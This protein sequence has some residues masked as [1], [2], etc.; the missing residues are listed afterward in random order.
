MKRQAEKNSKQVLESTMWVDTDL[1]SFGAQSLCERQVKSG[2]V[3]RQDVLRCLA[4]CEDSAEGAARLGPP[5]L[6][7]LGGAETVVNREREGGGD[8]RRGDGLPL[9]ALPGVGDVRGGWGGL[10]TPHHA[11]FSNKKQIAIIKVITI[12]NTVETQY[13]G[14]SL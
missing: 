1:S 12:C 8:P 13:S 9:V 2:E 6:V 11:T 7:A 14:T 5:L 3:H 4:T 10:G